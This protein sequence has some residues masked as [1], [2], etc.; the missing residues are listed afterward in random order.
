MEKIK[1]KILIIGGGNVGG[2]II[3]NID[4]FSSSNEVIGILDD[5]ISKIGKEFWGIKVVGTVNDLPKF[6]SRYERLGIVISIANPIIKQK[7]YNSISNTSNIF[8]PNF[9][10]NNTW[11]SK[12][13]KIGQGNIIYP[14]VS[15]NYETEVGDFTT[16]NM[17]VSIGHNC[18]INKFS[19][20]SPGVN[21][22]GFTR[23]DRGSFLGIG[24]CSTQGHTI[25]KYCTIGA[26]SVI[27]RDVPDYAVV[28]GNPGK[29]IKY[30]E[31]VIEIEKCENK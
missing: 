14:G 27:I 22:A 4:Q 13:V 10:H 25:G 28:V 2:F 3:N 19:T 5:D 8:F 7:I 24:C 15:I 16:I 9:I 23:V 29:I 20:L 11:I 17:N 12:K 26:G 6:T 21:I 1:E 31:P 18:C 30:H